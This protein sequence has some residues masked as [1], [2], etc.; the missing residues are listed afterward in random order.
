MFTRVARRTRKK[1]LGIESY[2]GAKRSRQTHNRLAEKSWN[3]GLRGADGGRTTHG[4]E[5]RRA[6]D[7]EST[8]ISYSMVN[9]VMFMTAVSHTHRS[10]L[11][12]AG[13]RIFPAIHF[14]PPRSLCA[15][16]SSFSSSFTFRPLHSP[17][18]SS[19]HAA[20]TKSAKAKIHNTFLHFF[21]ALC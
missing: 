10:D 3:N 13:E 15:S 2:R 5:N 1:T 16:L 20:I 8:V 14:T 17:F 4:S 6:L 7:E 19:A 9:A 21:R 18:R 11:Y 12:R